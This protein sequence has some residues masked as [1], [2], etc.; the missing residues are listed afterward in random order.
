MSPLGHRC[1]IGLIASLALLLARPA[2]CAAAHHPPT[3]LPIRAGGAFLG[4]PIIP[5]TAEARE[6]RI[7]LEENRLYVVESGQVVWSATVGTGTGEVL[8]GGGQVWDFSTPLSRYRVQQM[9][10]DPVWVLP[11]W[12]FVKEGA[13][14]FPWTLRSD[15][16]RAHWAHW[17]QRHCT[18]RMR[19]PSTEP[20]SRSFSATASRTGASACP[21]RTFSGSTRSSRSARRSSCTE[22]SQH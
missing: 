3:T 2:T 4:V 10:R 1:V 13:P 22:G 17:A 18:S 6:V 14:I 8:E 21:T 7:S 9:E 16:G 5:E 11:D 20:T 15:G 12:Y 19:S